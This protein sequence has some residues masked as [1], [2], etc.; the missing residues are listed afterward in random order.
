MNKYLTPRETGLT[1][2]ADADVLRV[3]LAGALSRVRQLF[4]LPSG[5]DDV[6]VPEMPS[7]RLGA[8]P[9]EPDIEIQ[10]AV[11]IVVAGAP[12]RV[13]VRA[14]G[15]IEVD[16][17]RVRVREP[18]VEIDADSPLVAALCQNA[19]DGVLRTLTD[20]VNT[21][22]VIP[23]RVLRC[24]LH[25]RIAA[26]DVRA[27]NE[28][29]YLCGVLDLRPDGNGSLSPEPVPPALPI[30]VAPDNTGSLIV[31]APPS[32]VG[33]LL[34]SASE[35]YR[36]M[37]RTKRDTLFAD[38]RIRGSLRIE[39]LQ[40]MGMGQGL[41]RLTLRLRFR[42]LEGGVETF[43]G[44]EWVELRVKRANIDTRMSLVL[45]DDGRRIKPAV[46]S[47]D[48]AKVK[49]KRKQRDMID[50]MFKSGIKNAIHRFADRIGERELNI[51]A[52]ADKLL[53]DRL[54]LD[55]R[56]APDGDGLQIHER[57]IVVHPWVHL[58][59]SV[60]AQGEPDMPA[61]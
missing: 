42:R 20:G 6:T 4:K 16:A 2:Y 36:H 45:S 47:L 25:V 11:E 53:D 7:V 1:L 5:L 19:V 44:Y 55:I 52:F 60:P 56:L 58:K 8:A 13:S 32:I 26:L 50:D 14:H 33:Q 9:D 51:S 35:N 39:D 41:V 18:V 3:G 12:V 27:V 31:L 17:D 61:D 40:V 30:P 23:R 22:A 38:V 21:R 15:S 57:A 54:P 46:Y 34:V 43:Y 49:F 59:Q 28:R 37:I 48:K 29:T 10:F 24:A